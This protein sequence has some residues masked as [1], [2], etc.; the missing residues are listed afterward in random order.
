[1]DDYSPVVI[2]CSSSSFDGGSCG[3]IREDCRVEDREGNRDANREE[4]LEDYR[5][6]NREGKREENRDAYR[7]EVPEA[8]LHSST[9]DVAKEMSEAIRQKAYEEGDEALGR[10]LFPEGD[11]DCDFIESCEEAIFGPVLEDRIFVSTEYPPEL[12]AGSFVEKRG[13][14]RKAPVP[15]AHAPRPKG[16]PRA[17]AEAKATYFGKQWRRHRGKERAQKKR[18]E[19]KE[20]TCSVGTAPLYRKK[21]GHLRI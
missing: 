15:A 1:M 21:R 20:A 2:S 18:R 10:V 13:R 17:S 7:E 3:I 5:D 6:A 12:I 19:E 16:R 9:V 8:A 11:D 14:K 4:N